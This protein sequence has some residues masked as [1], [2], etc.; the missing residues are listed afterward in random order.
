MPKSPRGW[1]VNTAATTERLAPDRDLIVLFG[2]NS[3]FMSFSAGYCS[4]SEG[5]APRERKCCNVR[6]YHD[7]TCD[8]FNDPSSSMTMAPR[9]LPLTA[10]VNRSPANTNTASVL[11]DGLEVNVAAEPCYSPAMLVCRSSKEFGDAD[12]AVT[13]SKAEASCGSNQ[14][15]E[16]A[17]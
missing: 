10:K 3:D 11:L 7:K 12:A 1:A 16:G 9:S 14:N 8:L 17:L 2:Q 6:C 15:L 5:V 13:E 4:S